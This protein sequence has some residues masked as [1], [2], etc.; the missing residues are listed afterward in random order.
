MYRLKIDLQANGRVLL[1]E[2]YNGRLIVPTNKEK[3]REKYKYF[4]NTLP[5]RQAMYWL[6]P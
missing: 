3:N 4:K 6:F 5:A 2:R 1:R